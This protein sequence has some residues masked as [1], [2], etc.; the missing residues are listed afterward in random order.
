[1]PPNRDP[2]HSVPLK[3]TEEVETPNWIGGAKLS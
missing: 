1:M 3:T 2:A